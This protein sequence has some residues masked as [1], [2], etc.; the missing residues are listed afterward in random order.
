MRNVKGAKKVELSFAYLSIEHKWRVN[1]QIHSMYLNGAIWMIISISH[2]TLIQN[3]AFRQNQAE[4]SRFLNLFKHYHQ[5]IGSHSIGFSSTKRKETQI[6]VLYFNPKCQIFCSF[7]KLLSN[8]RL[9]QMCS[10]C[11][12]INF[13]FFLC[14]SFL[15]LSVQM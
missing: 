7:F 6:R 10:L 3:H 12:D 11:D 5:L 13:F 2:F 4:S 1:K 9:I 8:V 14:S 15:F